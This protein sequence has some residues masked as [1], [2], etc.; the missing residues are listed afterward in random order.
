MVRVPVGTSIVS[1]LVITND[2]LPPGWGFS[3]R[4][5]TRLCPVCLDRDKKLTDER[6]AAQQR[7]G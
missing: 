1:G 3:T 4:F 5:N 2:A 6:I 7:K